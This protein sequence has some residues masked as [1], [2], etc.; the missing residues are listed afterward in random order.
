VTRIHEALTRAQELAHPYSL[1]YARMHAVIVHHL[2]L[3][4]QA[5]QEHAE[6]MVVICEEQE[7]VF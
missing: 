5:V 7:F 6:A 1:M 2:R 4:I 3:D